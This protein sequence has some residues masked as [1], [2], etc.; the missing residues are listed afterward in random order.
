MYSYQVAAENK[1]FVG[2]KVGDERRGE[3]FVG[4][5]HLLGLDF[6]LEV[7]GDLVET[8]TCFSAT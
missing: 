5:V 4:G 3:V 1:D 2:S 7:R 6:F 8:T